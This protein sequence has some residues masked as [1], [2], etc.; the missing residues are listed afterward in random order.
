MG[1]GYFAL[2]PCRVVDT[3]GGA[4]I[5]G[6][7]LQGQE[8]RSF[9]MIG[10]CGVPATAKALAIDIVATQ[11]TADGN[12]RLFPAGQPV[13]GS[14][15]I[16]YVTGRTRANNGIVQLNSL[17]QMAVFVAQP[18][19]STVHLVIDVHGYFE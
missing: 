16:N 19:G 12:M 14:S 18:L 4:P 8:T 13:P 17:G 11:P 10:N 6:P 9:T 1:Q 2:I 15:S 7:V 5:G 3:R